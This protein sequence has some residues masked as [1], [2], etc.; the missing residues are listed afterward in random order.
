M[1]D[2]DIMRHKKK[3]KKKPPPK[4]K[5]KHEYVNCVFEFND[6][7]FNKERGF[8]EVPGISIGT[9]CPICGKIES[10]FDY[11][12]KEWVID[13]REMLGNFTAFSWGWTDNAKREFDKNTRT[14]P[15]FWIEDKWFTKYVDLEGN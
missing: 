6:K 7:K 13:K 15:C 12:N 4:A 1:R 11:K 9:Y 10:T 5:H 3:S 8:I 2:D 14:L